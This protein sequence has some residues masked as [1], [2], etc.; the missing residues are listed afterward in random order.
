MV[1]NYEKT[2]IYKIY[3]HLGDKIYVG[4]TT[5]DFLSQRM[6]THRRCY[7]CW[8]SG[9]KGFNFVRAYVLFDEYGIDNCII[10]LLEAKPCINI[11]EAGKLEGIYIREMVCTNKQIAGRTPKEYREENKE[12]KSVISKEYYIKNKETIID[13][14]NR[15]Y[16]DNKEKI[17]E[18]R[19][20]YCEDN[21]EKIK[22]FRGEPKICDCG[23]FYTHA[24]KARHLKTLKHKQYLVNQNKL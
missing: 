5:K 13:R 8:K 17:K 1:I 12:K 7:K 16:E 22:E 9:K 6:A 19:K 4:S 10:E 24:H 21:K 2:K 14:S 11:H 23:L 15:Y 18:T 20:Q 3:S